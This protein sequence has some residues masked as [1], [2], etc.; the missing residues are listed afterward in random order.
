MMLQDVAVNKDKTAGI[1]KWI[2]YFL[3]GYALFSCT[4]IA[5]SNVFLGL[6]LAA[7]VYRLIMERSDWRQLLV[8]DK[9]LSLPF[10]LMVGVFVLTSL[11][12]TN[13]MTSGEVLLNHYVNRIVP[14]FLV[15]MF[16]R[17]KERL[18]KLA[19]LAG[20]SLLINDLVCIVQWN[21]IGGEYV[22]SRRTPGLIGTMVTGTV[23]AMLV[24]VFVLL[25]AEVKGRLRYALIG[26]LIIAI[27]GSAYN[28]TRGALLAMAITVCVT[29]FLYARSKKKAV[30]V[31]LVLAL[32]SAVAVYNVPWMKDRI[33]SITNTTTQTSNMERLYLWESSR[34]MAADYP[35]TGVGYGCF[36]K[37]YQEKYILPQ[38]IYRE[39]GHA[40]SNFFHILAENGYPGAIAV[41]LWWLSVAVWCIR[42]WMKGRN[43]V[44][45]MLLALFMGIML[46]GATEYTMGISLSMKFFWFAAGLCCRGIYL[47]EKE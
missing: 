32:A 23:N 21:V 15:L 20:I 19:I 4:S 14:F 10:G 27:L 17:E 28:D 36:A 22:R 39:L 31:L 7:S 37:N 6:A 9:K 40:H 18:I 41:C 25:L 8:V 2:F 47:M 11:F 45:L 1:E 29:A 46:E 12:S 30:A 24:P 13:I 35:L 16:V 42:G 38:A 44:Y 43:V 5:A 26:V 34:N 33:T 3:G